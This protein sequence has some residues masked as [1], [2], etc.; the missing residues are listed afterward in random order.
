MRE[1]A[2]VHYDSL[3]G[4][5]GLAFLI[6]LASHLSEVHGFGIIGIGHQGVWIFFLLSTFLISEY[7]LQK[8]QRAKSLQEWVNYASR[9]F[10]RIF[11]LFVIA[12][13]AYYFTG[14]INLQQLLGSL[15]LKYAW[16]HLWTIPVQLTSYIIIPF[17]L[18]I[19]IFALPKRTIPTILLIALL[20]IVVEILI[21]DTTNPGL[22]INILY[23]LPV[24]FYGII[25]SI[26]NDRL[27]RT[28]SE[29]QTIYLFEIIGVCSLLFAVVATPTVWSLLFYK[30][31]EGY[32]ANHSALL[33]LLWAIFL[34][35]L[36]NSHFLKRA[37]ANT[38]LRKIGKISYSGYLLHV[39][40]INT[41]ITYVS[42][43]EIIFAPISI[44]LTM[45]IASVT[46]L[47][48]EK[49]L[50]KIKLK[51]ILNRYN[52]LTHRIPLI[53]EPKTKEP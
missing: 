9:R 12:L 46:Y 33:G 31:S 43:R 4:L 23:Y 48:I 51:D 37:F 27:K 36:V 19:P 52:T 18:L 11:P 24:F 53:Q 42:S 16:G 10:F 35:C 41:V 5:R 26:I 40:I 32:F 39:L 21:P 3:D 7:F 14:Y 29:G 6:V 45:I 30:V 49:P 47:L 17:L 13:L 2:R 34:V 22:S 38:L 28:K 8:P 25:A 50:S 15:S 44:I 1:N 20:A